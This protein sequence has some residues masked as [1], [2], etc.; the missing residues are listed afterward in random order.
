VRT[1]QIGADGAVVRLGLDR[2]EA[3]VGRRLALI[4]SGL[5]VFRRSLAI[6]TIVE[7]LLDGRLDVW[8]IKG[9]IGSLIDGFEFLRHRQTDDTSQ[10]Q[11]VFFL[12][13]VGCDQLLLQTLIIDPGPQFIQLRRRSGCVIIH[14]LIQRNFRRVK[15]LLKRVDLRLICQHL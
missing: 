12:G 8:L 6:L 3:V 9:G 15:L 14:C 11:L 1:R 5:G 4:D 2:G 7:S 13:V 10:R